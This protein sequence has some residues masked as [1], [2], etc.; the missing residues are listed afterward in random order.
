MAQ[1][2]PLFRGD[3]HL[4]ETNFTLPE[5]TSNLDPGTR[6]KRGWTICNLFIHHQL[7]I[8]TIT[9]VLD[10]EVGNIVLALLK[11]GIIHDRRHKNLIPPLGIN[12]RLARGS[13]MDPTRP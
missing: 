3:F 7:S 12:R 5:N 4:K 8:Q 1:P 11:H 13:K 9:R 6:T 10:E 2:A